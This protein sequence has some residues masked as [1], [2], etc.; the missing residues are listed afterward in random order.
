MYTIWHFKFS[1]YK[2]FIGALN[3][4]RLYVFKLIVDNKRIVELK[5]KFII[6][7]E[8]EIFGLTFCKE[9]DCLLIATN[10]G[11]FGWNNSQRLVTKLS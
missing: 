4:G 3:D 2:L 5:E 11:L 9:N 8:C 1:I 7:L 6:D 10:N